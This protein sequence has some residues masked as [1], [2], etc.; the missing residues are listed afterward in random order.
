MNQ[1]A[2]VAVALKEADTPEFKEYAKQV[3][4][5]AKALA[6]SLMDAGVKLITD[7]T[8]NHMMV[9]D[10]VK[11]WSKSGKEIEKTL[12]LVGITTNKSMIPDD[13]NPPFNPS[14][15][16]LGTPAAT[17]RGMLE[18]DMQKLAGWISQA[19]KMSGD[20][21]G[22]SKLKSEIEEFC[23]TFPVPGI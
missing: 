15:L 13:P 18:P 9:I 17:T 7:G 1:I 23:Q 20:E 19:V 2:A 6:Q 11:S 8:D 16:R 12:D 14:G 5:N 10:C 21:V 22:L 3:L 4:L